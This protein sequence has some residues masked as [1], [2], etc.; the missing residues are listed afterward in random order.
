MKQD[1]TPAQRL[2]GD[3]FGLRGIPDVDEARVLALVEGLPG[4]EKGGN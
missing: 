3:L 2:W 1:L 4:R